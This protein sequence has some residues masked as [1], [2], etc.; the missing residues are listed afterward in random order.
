MMGE[1]PAYWAS[2]E[3]EKQCLD[4]NL[5]QREINPQMNSS[6]LH[7]ILQLPCSPVDQVTS[8]AENQLHR[9]TVPDEE[10]AGITVHEKLQP[11]PVRE[12]LKDSSRW[13]TVT[14]CVRASGSDYTWADSGKPQ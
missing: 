14:S 1:Q 5:Y 4:L 13:E 6:Q 2:R 3:N 10:G 7:C 12:Q 9:E 8:V 11:L